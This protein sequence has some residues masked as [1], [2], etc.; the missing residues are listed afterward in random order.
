MDGRIPPEDMMSRRTLLI[1]AGL[2]IAVGSIAPWATVSTPLGADPI[3]GPFGAVFLLFG[4]AIA[5]LGSR[6]IRPGRPTRNARLALGAAA[7]VVI[8][9]GLINVVFATTLLGASETARLRDQF[10][11]AG[12]AVT[13]SLGLYLLIAGGIGALIGWRRWAIEASRPELPAPT[14]AA[15]R[16]ATRRESVES[17]ATGVGCL[18]SP[19]LMFGSV[20]AWADLSLSH[21]Q[22]AAGPGGV[23]FVSGLVGVA[24][25]ARWLS[26]RRGR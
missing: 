17:I 2:L 18:L 23:A 10:G 25:L 8:A 12:V 9:I 5:W 4:G 20:I 13:P 19:L 21:P 14:V 6:S 26:R 1:G 22:E 7:V 3:A 15:R 16:P 24:L 11:P